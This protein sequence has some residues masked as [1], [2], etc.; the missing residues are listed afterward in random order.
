MPHYPHLREI[1]ILP[2]LPAGLSVEDERLEK[3]AP[4]FAL[5]YA[6]PND[7]L[8][9]VLSFLNLSKPQFLA[10][11]KR[12]KGID[13]LSTKDHGG[14]TGAW[15]YRPEYAADWRAMHVR[16]DPHRSQ[17]LGDDE[18]VEIFDNAS[19]SGQL[20]IAGMV[21][22]DFC[23][24]KGPY[25]ALGLSGRFQIGIIDYVWGSG[26]T[27][28]WDGAL[29]VDLSRGQAGTAPGYDFSGV[30]DFAIDYFRFTMIARADVP[31]GARWHA[32]RRPRAAL[33]A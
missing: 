21:D 27:V 8:A 3:T 18:I 15:R 14:E 9:R 10:L 2:C 30:C 1:A 24:P 12:R 31:R 29:T 7:A 25:P 26:H 33:A 32:E 6:M 16:H 19:Y 4:S 22:A 23:L 13:L 28:T 5:Q 17:L 11:V 20:A